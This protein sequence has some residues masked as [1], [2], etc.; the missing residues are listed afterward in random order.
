MVKVSTKFH[1][2]LF[3]S[4]I[5]ISL[6]LFH[7]S[8]DYYFFQDD[9]FEI[10][11]SQ[12]NNINEYL[13]F[14]TFR[15]DIIAY[16]PISLQNYFFIS[17]QIF[18][19]NPTGFR[20]ITL[21]F[22]ILSS[23]LITKIVSSVTGN[24]LTGMLTSSLWLISSI[25]FMAITWIAAA[26]NIIGT[27]F[28]LTTS[29]IFLKYLQKCKISFY[30]LSIIMFLI[31]VG[32]FEFSV[33]WP[34]VF[35]FYYYFVLKNSLIKSIKLFSPF[36][37][38]AIIYLLLRVVFIRIPQIHEYDLVFNIDS[39]KAL[40]WYFLWSFNIPEE[41]KK[42]IMDNIL[43]F[44]PVFLKDFSP[45]VFKTFVGSIW[46]FTLGLVVPIY[47]VV[48][49]KVNINS[50]IVLFSLVWFITAI[51]PVLLL[52]YHTFSMYL[53]LASIGIYMLVA[54]LVTTSQKT[55][56]TIP[57]ILIWLGTSLVTLNFYKINSWMIEA[58][59]FSREFTLG[60]Q[61]QYPIF[62]KNSIILYH[63]PDNRHIQA[64]LDQHAME[65]IYND[66]SLSIY[67]NKEDLIK[68]HKNF[69]DRPVYIYLPQ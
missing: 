26:Y 31:T 29:V 48:K 59:R 40:F 33:T 47:Y 51:F 58:S 54:Y 56:L 68:D 19:L 17:N 2:L 63:H 42:Q 65:T 55:F 62:P 53:T 32:S 10:N 67:Y 23:F 34:A 37:V 43:V 66:Q 24:R 41:F 35:G 1:V 27:F 9:F 16:R 50:R 64:L 45:L 57:I 22:F 13:E 36:I 18:D 52:P 25:H 20:F 3:F 12:A 49:D 61:K 69:G 28:W 60:I 30:L 14:Y 21:L 6:L 38:I 8:L 44:N 46:I 5:F 11:I 7:S 15:D 4:A 39:L